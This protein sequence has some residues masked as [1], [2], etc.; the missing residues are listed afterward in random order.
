M[1]LRIVNLCL[2][3]IGCGVAALAAAHAMNP[4]QPEPDTM[5]SCTVTGA[6]FLSPPLADDALCRRFMAGIAAVSGVARVELQILPQG[7]LNAAIT[8]TSGAGQPLQ[9]GLAISDRAAGPGDL[10]TLAA[11]ALAELGH[12]GPTT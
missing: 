9:L 2:G 1:A 6:K 8:R 11:Q 7:V 10:D 4:A 3:L 12:A 5:A